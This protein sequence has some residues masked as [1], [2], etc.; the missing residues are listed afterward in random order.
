MDTTF[1]TLGAFLVGVGLLMLLSELFVTSGLMFVLGVGS[2]LVGIVFLFRHDT[3]VGLYSLGGVAVILVVGGIAILRILPN[4]PLGQAARQP[5]DEEA[6]LPHYQEL[7]T[8][9]GR[10]GKTLTALRPAGM[11]DFDGR[12]VDSMTEGIMVEAGR[13]VRCIDVRGGT[14]IVRPIDHPAS[15]DLET[16]HL[17]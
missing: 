4:T 15:S 9:K 7:Q 3:Y 8:L 10:S 13:W 17:G 6:V 16:L 14:V 5:L 1:L 12:R 11:V 2:I